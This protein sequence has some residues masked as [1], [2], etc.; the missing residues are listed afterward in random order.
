M[1]HETVEEHAKAL[2]DGIQ[3]AVPGWV[4]RCVQGRLLDYYG[5]ADGEVMAAATG[6]GRRAQSDVGAAL[7]TLLE[8]DIDA[9]STTPLSLLRQAVR[10]PTEV[11]RSAGVPPVRRDPFAEKSFPDDDYDLTPAS[12][13]DVD[14]DLLELG[15]AWG[16]AKAEAHRRRHG[17]G[18]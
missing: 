10:Y 16:A 13:A 2:F 4:E 3:V 11:L 12:L 1:Q 17:G 6:A 8:T 14:Q 9:Q 18:P 5:A 7:R 15:L